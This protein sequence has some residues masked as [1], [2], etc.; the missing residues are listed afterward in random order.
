MAHRA[1]VDA[2]PAQIQGVV[3]GNE[4]LDAMPVKLLV[5]QG[6]HR[7]GVWHE[8]GVVLG[9]RCFGLGR[10]AHRAAPARRDRRPARLPDRNPPPGRG[11]IR[12]LAD[13]ASLAAA[14]A[15]FFL[16]Y[17]FPRVSTT[18]RSATWAP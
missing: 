13:R 1:W 12:T 5:R 16:D 2:L 17:G 10:P 11:F 18:T 9:G 15:I 6:G 4:V 3:V 8:R 14:G 7:A